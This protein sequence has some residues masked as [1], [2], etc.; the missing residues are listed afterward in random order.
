MERNPISIELGGRGH[1]LAPTFGAIKRIEQELDTSVVTAYLALATGR[2]TLEEMARIVR[3]GMNAH[4]DGSA[5]QGGVE[6]RLFERGV[7]SDAVRR[8]VARYLLEL[9]WAPEEA[10]AKFAA[11][12]PAP[13]AKRS[14]AGQSETAA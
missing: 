5:S 7:G 1:Q 6:K 10:T 3:I 12:W 13:A 14:P 11:E 2:L 8:A 4:E 9:G